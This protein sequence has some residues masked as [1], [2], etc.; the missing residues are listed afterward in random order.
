[1]ENKSLEEQLLIEHAKSAKADLKIKHKEAK[2]AAKDSYVSKSL[3]ES[4]VDYPD[5]LDDKYDA[6]RI[7]WFENL[8]HYYIL[9]TEAGLPRAKRQKYI[10]QRVQLEVDVMEE[11]LQRMMMVSSK[12]R[13]D[14]ILEYFDD[15]KKYTAHKKDKSTGTPEC[16][17]LKIKLDVLFNKMSLWS[18]YKIGA[19]YFFSKKMWKP[20]VHYDTLEKLEYD[21]KTAVNHYMGDGPNSG[22]YVRTYWT[23]SCITFLRDAGFPE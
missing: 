8:L 17:A 7:N 18:V 21:I 6:G 1:M 14:I 11:R 9:G 16:V 13:T 3:L 19:P 4:I 2:K 20:N 10:D 5:Y 15:L 23:Y 12:S 22:E